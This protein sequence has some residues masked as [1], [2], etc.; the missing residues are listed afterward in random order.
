LSLPPSSL[1]HPRNI[2]AQHSSGLPEAVFPRDVVPD[3]RSARPGA[4]R[5]SSGRSVHSVTREGGKRQKAAA[6]IVSPRSRQ[7][8]LGTS[9]PSGAPRPLP[10][11]LTTTQLLS[12][13]LALYRP[14]EGQTADSSCPWLPYFRTLPDTFRDWHPLTWLVSI[15]AGLRRLSDDNAVETSDATQSSTTWNLLNGLAKEHLSSSVKTKLQDVYRRYSKDKERVV[16]VMQT[17][18]DSTD[19]SGQADDWVKAWR[20]ATEEDFLWSWLNGEPYVS[21]LRT[22]SSLK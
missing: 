5:T 18:V 4:S 12:L 1:L 9:T 7:P 22:P 14:V 17:L 11:N 15:S 6:D 3:A 13:Y 8:S 2:Y 19:A 21:H 10:L 16:D 20:G